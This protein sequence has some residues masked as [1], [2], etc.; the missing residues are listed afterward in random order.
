MSL[1]EVGGRGDLKGG[2]RVLAQPL[3]EELNGGE[4]GCES[5]KLAFSSQS[6]NLI[7]TF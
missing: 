3:D 4:W 1:P 2:D 6:E 5:R 7:K